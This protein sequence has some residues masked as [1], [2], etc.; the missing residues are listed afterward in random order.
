MGHTIVR[1]FTVDWIQLWWSSCF[2]RGTMSSSWKRVA[3]DGRPGEDHRLTTYLQHN[4]RTGSASTT[5]GTNPNSHER[6]RRNIRTSA[7]CIQVRTLR[8]EWSDALGGASIMSRIATI[9]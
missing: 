4:C 3:V 9:L 1:I 5:P 2:Q 7:S 6:G 8:S